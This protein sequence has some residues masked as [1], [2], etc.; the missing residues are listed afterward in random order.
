MTQDF[1]TLRT[2][3]DIVNALSVLHFNL[4][5]IERVFYDIFMNPTKMIVK[6]Q[7]YD[8]QGVLETVEVKNLAMLQS[9]VL[10]GSGDPNGAIEANAG[11]LYLDVTGNDVYYKNGSG[12]DGWYMLWSNVNLDYLSPTGN[13]GGLTDLNASSVTQGALAVQYGGT[14]VDGSTQNPL[15]S[16]IVKGNGTDPMSKAIDGIDYLGPIATVGVICYYPVATIPSGWLLCDGS[17]YDVDGEYARLGAV[18]GT[19]YNLQSDSSDVFRVPNL[20]SYGTGERPYYIRSWDGSSNVGST[21]DWQVGEHKH[22]LTGETGIEDKHMH[23]KGTHSNGMRIRGTFSG[24]GQ[25]YGSTARP[26]TLTGAFYRVNTTNQPSQGVVIR[27]T[28]GEKDDYFG[29]DTNKR[30][31]GVEA[32]T[33]TTGIPRTP[34]SVENPTTYTN[35]HAHSL[36][37]KETAENIVDSTK[38]NRVRSMM[39]VPIIKY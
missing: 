19:T 12:T 33:G 31:G 14:G 37:G 11:A 6:M 26:A 38:E 29:F 8:D 24:V 20:M 5:E 22:P 9:D 35:G 23:D 17:A 4:N 28:D 7:R 16:G 10:T 13:G 30:T 34:D 36:A 25:A 32:W 15:I 27:N 18:L 1:N 2:T 21:Q 3:E 39:M